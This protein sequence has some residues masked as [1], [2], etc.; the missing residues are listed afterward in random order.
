MGVNEAVSSCNSRRLVSAPAFPARS[1]TRLSSVAASHGVRQTTAAPENA[2]PRPLATRGLA[3]RF[4]RMTKRS[5]AVLIRNG[6]RILTTRRS[7]SD[8]ELPGIWGLPAGTFRESE[9]VGDLIQRIGDQKLGV[10][11]TPIRKLCQGRQVRPTYTLEMDLWEAT[12]EGVPGH[13]A[14]KWANPEVLKPGRA[15]G[16]LCCDLALR[17]FEGA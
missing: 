14:W 8:D 15:D 6:D 17:G 3:P 12:M 11:L 10:R 9:T 2:L 1:A 7:D 4:S 16:S 13:P 5:I